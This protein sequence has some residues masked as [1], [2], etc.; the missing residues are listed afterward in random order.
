MELL[1][2]DEQPSERNPMSNVYK[3]VEGLKEYL[4]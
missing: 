2:K 1:N 4:E 3:I